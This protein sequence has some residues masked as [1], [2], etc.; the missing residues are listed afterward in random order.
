MYPWDLQILEK[1]GVISF[2]A[3]SDTDS[4][5]VIDDDDIGAGINRII[6]LII[7]DCPGDVIYVSD[8]SGNIDMIESIMQK[9]KV[10]YV[11]D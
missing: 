2:S 4:S 9:R 3:T 6:N 7:T 8:L 11:I 10:A 1:D 5:I